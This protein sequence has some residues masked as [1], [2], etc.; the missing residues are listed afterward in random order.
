MYEEERSL[1]SFIVNWSTQLWQKKLATT[2]VT[3]EA[4]S[5]QISFD[6]ENSKRLF[7][8]DVEDPDIQS[9]YWTRISGAAV[10]SNKNAKQ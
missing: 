4:L 9:S 6:L 2:V 7:R 5:S 8:T 1:A 3:S 10:P